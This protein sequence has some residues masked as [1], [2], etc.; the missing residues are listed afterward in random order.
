[1]MA[2]ILWLFLLDMV[3]AFQC[4]A[5]YAAQNTDRCDS[6]ASATSLGVGFRRG[7][8]VNKASTKK[9]LPTA[10]PPNQYLPLQDDFSTA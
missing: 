4:L 3:S 5:A 9:T 8:N 2:G 1:M 6:S 7:A 10:N